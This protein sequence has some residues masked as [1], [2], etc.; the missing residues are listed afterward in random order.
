MGGILNILYVPFGWILHFIFSFIQSYGWSLIIFTILMR[1]VMFPLSISQQKSSAKQAR[2][3]PKIKKIQQRFAGNQAK[4]NEEMQKLYDRENYSMMNA[5]CL[6]LLIQM[7]I[8]MGL[9]GVIYKPITYVLRLPADSVK[10]LTETA[11]KILEDAGQWGSRSATIVELSVLNMKDQV[12]AGSGVSQDVADTIQ[13]FDFHF[14]G[15]PLGSVPSFKEPSILW[16]IPILSFVSSLLMGVYTFMKQRKTNPEMA[17]NPM[18]GCMSFVMPI[19]S[20]VLAFQ[21]PVGIGIYWT[22]SNIV[23]LIQTVI[24]NQTHSPQ[25]IIARQMI[26]E[27]IMRRSRENNIRAVRQREE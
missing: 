17:K 18:M 3:Q 2:L 9:F 11:K 16:I 6:P 13:N 14:L 19:F 27:T 26:E 12:L 15:L 5:G 8:I 21:F 1:L 20:L 22:M 7:P 24:V 25:K 4:I 23:G 10:V